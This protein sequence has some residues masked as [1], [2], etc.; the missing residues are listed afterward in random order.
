[1]GAYAYCHS[2]K[3]KWV[4]QSTASNWSNSRNIPDWCPLPEGGKER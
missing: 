2:V 3:L 4:F 1:M